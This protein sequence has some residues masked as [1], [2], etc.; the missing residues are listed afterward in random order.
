VDRSE[1][2]PSVALLRLVN[3]DAFLP[4]S[5]PEPVSVHRSLCVDLRVT[6]GPAPPA[7]PVPARRD[8]STPGRLN[9]Y[10]PLIGLGTLV[11]VLAACIINL[12][13]IART[14][15]GDGRIAAHPV[16]LVL[17]VTTFAII[18]IVIGAII[19]RCFVPLCFRCNHLDRS[20][21]TRGR[22]VPSV[23]ATARRW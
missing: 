11:L 21:E 16:H 23:A 14:L 18:A 20:T 1:E 19:V 12:I 9:A 13:P 7:L 22:A 4:G 5:W 8:A 6:V 2:R 17:A 15:R 3:D 10:G